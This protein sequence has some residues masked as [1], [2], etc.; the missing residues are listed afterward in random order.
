LDGKPEAGSGSAQSFPT[1]ASAGEPSL[2]ATGERLLAAGRGFAVALAALFVA[3]ARLLK[4]RI[5]LVFLAGVALVAFAVSLWACAVALIGWTFRIATGSTGA[6]LGLLVLLHVILVAASWWSI[7]RGIHA[8]G[9]P[10]TR[11]ELAALRRGLRRNAA[12]GGPP[13]TAPNNGNGP[14]HG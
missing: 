6:A 3:E 10:E 12:A 1:G 4:Q 13:S 8:A 7:Q 14:A 5:G 2:L 9:F 11:S